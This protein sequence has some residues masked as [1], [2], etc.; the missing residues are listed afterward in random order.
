MSTNPS[1]TGVLFL[2]IKIFEK[3]AGPAEEKVERGG[4]TW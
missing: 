2:D 3:Y 4:N 1:I